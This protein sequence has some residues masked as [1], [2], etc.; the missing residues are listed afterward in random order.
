MSDYVV[1]VVLFERD[2]GEWVAQC[3]QYD[4]GAQAGTLPDL[5]YELQR[6][7]VGH[8][9]IAFENEI[10][11][12]VSLPAAPEEYWEKWKTAKAT[13]QVEAT[14]FRMPMHAPVVLPRLKL[15]A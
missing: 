5:L 3:L 15:A 13:V 4:I 10:E 8:M 6:S 12:F 2:P 7:L 14:P 1:D 11:P 9:V